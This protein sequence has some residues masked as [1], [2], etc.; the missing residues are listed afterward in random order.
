MD[1]DERR[2]REISGTILSSAFTVS[3]ELGIGFLEKVYENA[4]FAELTMRGLKVR[5]Q[6]PL[7]VRYKGVLVGDY[8]ADLV[9]EDCVLVELK[10][11]KGLED[12][13]SAQCLNYLRASGFH[14]CLL[15][16]FGKPQIEYKRIVHNL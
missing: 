13:F 4:L 2:Y 11:V 12:V 1:A 15:L 10:H 9:V 16:N 5:Q 3:N 14:L 6:E 7:P 8:Y